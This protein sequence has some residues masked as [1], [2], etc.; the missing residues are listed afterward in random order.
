MMTDRQTRKSN[1]E[2]FV[3]FSAWQTES[4]MPSFAN[5]L[6]PFVLFGHKVC[7]AVT[8]HSHCPALPSAL[9]PLLSIRQVSI[10]L[11]ISLPCSR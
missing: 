6:N 10:T 4:K 1:E 9:L 2:L 8:K 7:L 3:Q 11:I 5:L